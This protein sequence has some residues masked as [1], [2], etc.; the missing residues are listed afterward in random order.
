[1]QA[2]GRAWIAV[3]VV[4]ALGVAPASAGAVTFGTNLE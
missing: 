2:I 1:M 3:G 4:V